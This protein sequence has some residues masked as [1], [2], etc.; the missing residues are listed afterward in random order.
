MRISWTARPTNS[1]MKNARCFC[2]DISFIIWTR[3]SSSR[4]ILYLK[5]PKPRALLSRCDYHFIGADL[6]ALGTKPTRRRKKG[7]AERDLCTLPASLSPGPFHF[8]DSVPLV[9]SGKVDWRGKRKTC[10]H[11]VHESGILHHWKVK[12]FHYKIFQQSALYCSLCQ[13]LEQRCHFQ[14]V[15]YECKQSLRS[16]Y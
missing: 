1:E 7:W 11:T 3:R 12:C 13:M 10:Q 16:V 15:R 6:R 2:D 4:I 9:L 5:K 8:T 14:S